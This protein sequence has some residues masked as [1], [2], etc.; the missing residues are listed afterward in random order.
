MTGL[1][2]VT[3]TPVVQRVTTR[4]LLISCIKA[5]QYT[6]PPLWGVAGVGRIGTGG[7]VHHL[8]AEYVRVM[9]CDGPN[10]GDI[11]GDRL[12]DKIAG[13]ETMVGT[14]GINFL[15]AQA[16]AEVEETEE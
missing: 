1:S 16:A 3:R 2:D 12:E 13:F 6:A 9:Y 7:G 5:A 15:G 14:G 11:C 10:Y 8:E 4:E